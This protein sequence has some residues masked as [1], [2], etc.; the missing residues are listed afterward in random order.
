MPFFPFSSNSGVTYQSLENNQVVGM[1]GDVED[2][3]ITEGRT[4][5]EAVHKD[6]SETKE[7]WF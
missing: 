1:Q 3:S 7:Q 6:K 4:D 5:S 2:L